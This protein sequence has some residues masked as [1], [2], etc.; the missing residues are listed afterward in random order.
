MFLCFGSKMI[1]LLFVCCFRF[2]STR[3]FSCLL[4]SF[5]IDP[6][7]F[8][9]ELPFQFCCAYA[10]SQRF[11]QIYFVKC[12]MHFYIIKCGVSQAVLRCAARTV[13]SALYFFT[14]S[15]GAVGPIRVG[16]RLHFFRGR[17][18]AD[19]G[20]GLF[21]FFRGRGRADRGGLFYNL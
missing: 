8:C 10:A 3:L 16:G 14:F 15:E 20:G 5:Q 19:M 17:G 9:L 11:V 7:V 1:R 4:C 18:R 2:K 13:A 21:T 12:Y 6:F